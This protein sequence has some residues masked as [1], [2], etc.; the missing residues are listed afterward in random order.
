MTY[1]LSYQG[2]FP[3]NNIAALLPCAGLKGW[4]PPRCFQRCD[5]NRPTTSCLQTLFSTVTPQALPTSSRGARQDSG[6]GAGFAKG[7]SQPSRR[8]RLQTQLTLLLDVV[9]RLGG[10]G[11]VVGDPSDDGRLGRRPAPHLQLPLQELLGLL[12]LRREVQLREG[13]DGVD[14]L[15]DGFIFQESFFVFALEE[16]QEVV[17]G[18]SRGSCVLGDRAFSGWPAECWVGDSVLP[19]LSGSLSVPSAVGNTP[20]H[21]GGGRAALP[22]PDLGATLQTQ[23]SGLD[24]ARAE[25]CRTSGQS[26]GT[27]GWHEQGTSF[28]ANHS[29]DLSHARDRC[30]QLIRKEH[31]TCI[32]LW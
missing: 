18:M 11:F 25:G 13:L 17:R 10:L 22:L 31:A 4:M 19:P 1:F 6:A 21:S 30:R 24:K 7:C 8:T 14:L 3:W 9:L 12:V 28:T 29:D 23:D 2:F 5:T 20:G 15:G 16:T 27:P 26:G 32:K